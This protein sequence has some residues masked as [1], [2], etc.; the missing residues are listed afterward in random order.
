MKR[1]IL[2]LVA[3]LGLVL[4]IL[5]GALA[6]EGDM[7]VF[8]VEPTAGISYDGYL[9]EV[10]DGVR[11]RISPAVLGMEEVADGLYLAASVE[12]IQLVFRAD[13]ILYIEPNYE[14]ELFVTP[15]DPLFGSLQWDM[16]FV[17]APIFWGRG[18]SAAGVRVAVIDSGITLDHEDL[19]P[20]QIAAGWN[21]VDNNANV[22]DTLGH[23][24]QVT[25]ILAAARG[26]GRGMAG[27]LDEVT[28]V[29]LRVFQGNTSNLN[30]AIQAIRDAVDVFD[31]DVI[32]V[33][34]GARGTPSQALRNAV[35]HAVNNGA[36]IVASAG[37]DGNTTRFYPASFPNVVS[38]GAVDQSGN[39]AWFSQRNNGL[40]V[41]APGVDVV[42]LDHAVRNRYVS[43][44]G[45]SFA[46]PHVTAMAAAARAV[47][48]D[49][50]Q[51]QFMNLL[52]GSAVDRGSVGFDVMFGYGTVCWNR[53]LAVLPGVSWFNDIGGHWAN[54]WIV[55]M[56]ELG[57]VSG[58]GNGAFSPYRNMTRA[59]FVTVLGRLYRQTGG[60]I[61][62]RNDGF[63]DTQNNSWYSRYV[64]WAA[65]QSIVQGVGGNRFQPYGSITREQAI[66]ILAN[67]AAHLGQY[68]PG[69][70]MSLAPFVDGNHVSHWAVGPMAWSVEQ[71]VIQGIPVHNGRALW[72]TVTA[73]RAELVVMLAQFMAQV[74][75]SAAA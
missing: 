18:I 38:V 71:G 19:N 32:N 60:Y 53:F 31:V 58:T 48:G 52:R 14:I 73:Q 11:P 30:L 16:R 8:S 22:L 2:F 70:P 20:A 17:N 57:L 3:I 54:G 41:A 61:P 46:A 24:T 29:P 40:T 13:Q 37:N 34:F 7:S 12:D 55:N 33:S 56:A 59:E 9:V 44:S 23:G 42:T 28:I 1:K 36:I 4:L 68:S 50:T 5:P 15:N 47:D 45:T 75:L 51:A 63:I 27:L 39:I 10:R 21:Y 43:V 65:E 6:A 64:A 74:G 26:N 67:F 69:N 66:T 49:I 72:P 25:G 35:D 62:V